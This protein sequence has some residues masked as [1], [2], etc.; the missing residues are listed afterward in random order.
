MSLCMRLCVK[1][2][3]LKCSSV[4]PGLTVKFLWEGFFLQ[5]S[6]IKK[7]KKTD[8][9]FGKGL[10]GAWSIHDTSFACGIMTADGGQNTGLLL[11]VCSWAYCYWSI[12]V[13][14]WNLLEML[15]WTLM[16]Q[17]LWTGSSNVAN[18]AWNTFT[19]CTLCYPKSTATNRTWCNGLCTL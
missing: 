11:C 12:S 3:W 16:E 4:T 8:F 19:L 13:L 6:R 1:S 5:E 18:L 14:G 9:T 10:S 15:D 7:I 17:S 2:W